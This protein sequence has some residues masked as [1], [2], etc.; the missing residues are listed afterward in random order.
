MIL[1]SSERINKRSHGLGAN[2]GYQLNRTWDYVYKF[3][4]KKIGTRDGQ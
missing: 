1:R 4:R 2:E 3:S